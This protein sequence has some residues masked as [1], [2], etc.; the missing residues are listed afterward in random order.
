[1][2]TITVQNAPDAVI[3]V[4][5]EVTARH[6][7]DLG[8]ETVV[9]G[10]HNGELSNVA[11]DDRTYLYINGEWYELVEIGDLYSGEPKGGAR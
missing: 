3:G 10:I 11:V 5:A 4:L 6:A 8:V 1:M 9:I 2:S 7:R